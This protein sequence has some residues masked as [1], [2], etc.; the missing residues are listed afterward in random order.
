MSSTPS[1]YV[2]MGSEGCIWGHAETRGQ[3]VIEGLKEPRSAW[4]RRWIGRAA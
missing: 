2:V 3:A 1:R 4:P